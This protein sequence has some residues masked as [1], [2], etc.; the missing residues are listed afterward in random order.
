MPVPTALEYRNE[1]HDHERQSDEGQKN[2]RRQKWEINGRDQS[3]VS[4][5]FFTDVRV[6]NN[7]ADQKTGRRNEGRDHAGNMALPDI[8]PDPEP[9]HADEDGAD[10]IEQRVD[11]G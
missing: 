5:R 8:A 11:R 6:I 9:A 7:V 2:M 1:G 10:Q 3:G 4:G